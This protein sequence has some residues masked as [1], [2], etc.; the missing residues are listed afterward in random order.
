MLAQLVTVPEAV[1]VLPVPKAVPVPVV[2]VLVPAR[3]TGLGA[4]SVSSAADVDGAGDFT[5][6]TP[7]M[8]V[9]IQAGPVH[10][11]SRQGPGGREVTNAPKASGTK[12][13]DPSEERGEGGEAVSSIS[14]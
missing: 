5:A 1:P 12:V 2:L 6:R 13:K 11:V 9:L 8:A 10:L 7:P 3:L 4:G 14:S